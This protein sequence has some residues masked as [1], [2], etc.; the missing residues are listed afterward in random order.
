MSF[1]ANTDTGI[2][3]NRLSQDLQLIDMDL[4]VS[5]LNTSAGELL[6]C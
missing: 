5:A 3:L 2:T 1:F 6:S 4:P